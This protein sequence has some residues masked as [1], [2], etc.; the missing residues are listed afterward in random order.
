MSFHPRCQLLQTKRLGYVVITASL[1]T[2]HLILLGNP[3]C[4]KQNRAGDIFTD[5]FAQLQSVHFRHIDVKQDQV[6]IDLQHRYC[7][8][9]IFRCKSLVS[10]LLQ[11]T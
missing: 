10:T 7:P 8:I 6:R 4:Q 11:V 5:N 9:C 2:V 1:Q 3:G